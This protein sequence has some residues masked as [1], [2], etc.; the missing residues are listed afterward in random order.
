[1]LLVR[2]L[3]SFSATVAKIFKAIHSIPE[4]SYDIYIY[5]CIYILGMH[6]YVVDMESRMFRLSCSSVA[7][8]LRALAVC[9]AIELLHKFCNVDRFLHE[10]L[11]DMLYKFM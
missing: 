8:L 2:V 3:P 5:I 6:A 10:M 4:F 11:Q 1:M 9:L 7:I